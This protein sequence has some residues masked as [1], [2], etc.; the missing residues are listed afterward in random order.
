MKTSWKWTIPQ[1]KSKE[2]RNK[3]K[4]KKSQKVESKKSRN[5]ERERE[6]ESKVAKLTWGWLEFSWDKLAYNNSKK[7]WW[8]WWC[9]EERRV[10]WRFL[11]GQC[12]WW[13]ENES[14]KRR[15][16]Q[17]FLNRIEIQLQAW[18]LYTRTCV[19][20]ILLYLHL[21]MTSKDIKKFPKMNEWMNDYTFLRV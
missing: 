10:K 5:R 6:R 17:D 13:N 20:S 21:H 12:W 2:E 3:C 8:W 16:L 15:A 14:E 9:E 7:L 4:R 18:K 11:V 19:Y 1:E